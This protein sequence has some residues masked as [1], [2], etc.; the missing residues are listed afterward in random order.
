MHSDWQ[1]YVYRP[2]RHQQTALV[3]RVFDI[4]AGT[5]AAYFMEQE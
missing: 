5:L 2:Q 3:K 1:L 4:L